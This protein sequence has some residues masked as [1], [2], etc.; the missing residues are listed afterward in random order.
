[1]DGAEVAVN[2]LC[3]VCSCTTWWCPDNEL[4]DAHLGECK[5]RRMAEVMGELDA[6]YT[7]I[8]CFEEMLQESYI[9]GIALLSVHIPVRILPVQKG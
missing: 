3:S 8:H 1:M 7:F 6:T 4:A 5:Y 9:P 2:C